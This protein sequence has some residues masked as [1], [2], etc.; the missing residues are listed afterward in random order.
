LED[1]AKC[2]E[3]PTTEPPVTT[4]TKEPFVCRPGEYYN[5]E[6][7]GDC[8]RFILCADGVPILQSCAPK[9]IFDPTL[10]KCVREEDYLCPYTPSEPPTEP[11]KPTT[12]EPPQPSTIEPPQP[13]TIEPPQPSTIEPPVETTTENKYPCPPG[14]PLIY[15]PHDEDCAAFYICRNGVFGGVFY[16]GRELWFS[17]KLQGCVEPRES[18]CTLAT[19][20]PLIKY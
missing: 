14:V 7:V 9:T 5:V 4:T 13:T 3:K 15:L 8:T 16:C 2:Y 18:D 17:T 19:K 10:A 20:T 1:E 6:V 11:P 12:V